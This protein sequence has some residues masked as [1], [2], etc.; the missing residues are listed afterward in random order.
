LFTALRFSGPA[1]ASRSSAFRSQH[2]GYRILL[3]LRARPHFVHSIA[4][5]GSCS[6]FALI[7]ISF[8]AL[9]LS[10]LLALRARC[11]L[12]AASLCRICSRF[13]LA[14][15][16]RRFAFV[17]YCSRFALASMSWF[18]RLFV[19]NASQLHDFNGLLSNFDGL[20]G[21]FRPDLREFRCMC[22]I[23]NQWGATL[24]YSWLTFH[25]IWLAKA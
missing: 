4:V 23:C 1:R 22:V 7:R 21:C 9:R 8:T 19:C 17:A 13:A 15:S 20:L 10:N 3:A 6:R 11:T 2:C 16:V 14:H 5:I 24:Q 18:R 12:F 25:H